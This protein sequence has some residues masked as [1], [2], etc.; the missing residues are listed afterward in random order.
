[1]QAKDELRSITAAS[2]LLKTMSNP[3]RLAI[4]CCLKEDEM[5]VGEIAEF[6]EIGQSSL[7]QHLSKLRDQGLVHTRRDQQMIYYS[8]ASG[9]VSEIIKV[10]RTLYCKP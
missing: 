3:Q 8:L 6:L 1:M 4:L 9:E 10:L 7:S 2:E 5:S